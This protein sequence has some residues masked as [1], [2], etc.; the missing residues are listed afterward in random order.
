[1]YSRPDGLEVRVTGISGGYLGLAHA[2]ESYGGNDAAPTITWEP[3]ARAASYAVTCFDPDAPT[4]SGVWHW[5]MTDI[6]RSVTTIVSGDPPR[7]GRVFANDLGVP[8]YS[9]AAP[10]PGSPHRYEF[11]VWALDIAEVPLPEGATNALA[12]FFVHQHAIAA[13]TKVALFGVSAA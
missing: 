11:T 1:M 8:G 2:A 10:P 6:P 9:G 12:R 5:V 7:G 4:G 3:V 13:G